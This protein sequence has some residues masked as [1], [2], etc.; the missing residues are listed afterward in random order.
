M[1]DAYHMFNQIEMQQMDNAHITRSKP[2]DTVVVSLNLI[3]YAK[4]CKL[5][6]TNK[7]IATDYRSYLIN[8]NLKRCY[9]ACLSS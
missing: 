7:I 3:E 6:E 9:G 2:A 4:G 1:Q 5:L 8:V